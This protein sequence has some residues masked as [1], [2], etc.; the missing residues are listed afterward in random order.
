MSI[1]EEFA[2]EYEKTGINNLFR[3][4]GTTAEAIS[5]WW[6]S[7]FRQ[8]LEENQKRDWEDH[9]SALNSILEDLK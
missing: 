7:R 9:N 8:M 4:D 5:D 3:K 1:R 2:T 6:I